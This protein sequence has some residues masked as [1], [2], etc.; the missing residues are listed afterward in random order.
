VTASL[1]RWL[2]VAAAAVLLIVALAG[3]ALARPQ[4]AVGTVVEPGAAVGQAG[5]AY[6]TGL[7]VVAADMLWNRLDPLQ[8]YYTFGLKH[9]RFM[10]PN[11][12]IINWLDPQF[13]DSYFVGPEI[14]MENGRVKEALALCQQG[15]D[16][17]PR[18]GL[19][20]SSEAQYYLTKTKNLAEAVRL[21]DRAMQPDTIWRWDDE[22]WQGYAFMRGIYRKAG[23][24]AKVKQCTAV[25]HA[26]DV[27]PNATS[28]GKTYAPTRGDQPP[29]GVTVPSG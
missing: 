26:I 22:K 5:Y 17:N 8:D 28:Q 16:N 20:I 18:S 23:M 14:L 1:R 21:A 3:N 6:L 7:R 27:N 25:M 9:M 24:T 13:V 10:L 12:F 4:I 29:A 19:L 15:V 2:A 11:F